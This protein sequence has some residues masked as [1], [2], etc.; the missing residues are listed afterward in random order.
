MNNHVDY[1]VGHVI[2]EILEETLELCTNDVVLVE[3]LIEVV[4]KALDVE[5]DKIIRELEKIE[6]IYTCNNPI[7]GF[8]LENGK[9]KPYRRLTIYTT[10][11]K[12]LEKNLSNF[13]ASERI[14]ILE[15]I[16]SERKVQPLKFI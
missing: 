15:Q 9:Y 12:A 4:S 6:S 8:I 16:T 7:Q 11:K 14:Q 2:E 13:V 10:V 1:E 5:E 3:Q